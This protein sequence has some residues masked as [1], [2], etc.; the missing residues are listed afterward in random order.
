MWPQSSLWVHALLGKNFQLY[1]NSFQCLSVI[2]YSRASMSITYRKQTT[3]HISF[4]PKHQNFSSQSFTVRTFSKR[5]PSVSA[6]ATTC[7]GWRFYNFL[8]F[9]TSRKQR[10]DACSGLF[11]SCMYGMYYA[12]HSI[13]SSFSDNMELQTKKLHAN[14]CCVRFFFKWPRPVSDLKLL[15]F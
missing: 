13:G 1:N 15:T 11:A 2:K 7:W 10:L 6:T 8:L 14:I 5:R 3:S 4:N 12:A 9:L